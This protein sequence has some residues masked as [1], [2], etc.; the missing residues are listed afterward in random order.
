MYTSTR[1]SRTP[2]QHRKIEHHKRVYHLV[3]LLLAHRDHFSEVTAVCAAIQPANVPP[4]FKIWYSKNK[5]TL[6]SDDKKRSEEFKAL[7]VNNAS[8]SSKQ[9][10]NAIFAFMKKHSTTRVQRMCREFLAIAPKIANGLVRLIKSDGNVAWQ[11]KTTNNPGD[12]AITFSAKRSGITPLETMLVFLT[13]VIDITYR[14]QIT[15]ETED[16]AGLCALAFHLRSSTLLPRFIRHIKD[17]DLKQNAFVLF[18]QLRLLGGI[19]RFFHFDVGSSTSRTVC[20][21]YISSPDYRWRPDDNKSIPKARQ[22]YGLAVNGHPQKKSSDVPSKPAIDFLVLLRARA[23]RIK[24][25]V[26]G[27]RS[28]WEKTY[29]GLLSCDGVVKARSVIHAE[30]TLALNVLLDES[31][32][33]GEKYFSISKQPCFLC[34][35]WFDKLSSSITSTTFFLSR[36]D[37]KNCTRVGYFPELIVSTKESWRKFGRNSTKSL[38]VSGITRET[39]LL[40]RFTT[41]KRQKARLILRISRE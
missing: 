38:R 8:G 34:E 40:F 20:V 6:A 35:T 12:V 16:I 26:P 10:C 21:P 24:A 32:A 39:I 18:D 15:L 7:V 27:G 1:E 4:T 14:A 41:D 29:P 2:I 9:F 23:S 30:V 5:A 17:R 13:C 37:T 22:K 19:L 3:A 25:K 31:S 28:D 36:K 33:A 11:T